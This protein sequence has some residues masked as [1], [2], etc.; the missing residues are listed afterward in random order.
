MG[1]LI[2]REVMRLTSLG[3]VP[4]SIIMSNEA[5][6]QLTIT[7]REQLVFPIPVASDIAYFLGMPVYPM[8]GVPIDF[9]VAVEPI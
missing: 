6:N 8:V 2:Y 4:T 9:Q 3:L 5:Y 7:H 1:S